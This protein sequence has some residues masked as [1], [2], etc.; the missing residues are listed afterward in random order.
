MK[1]SASA[2]AP[3]E[4][5]AKLRTQVRRVQH[6]RWSSSYRSNVASAVRRF[7]AC[8]DCLGLVTFPPHG[9][10]GDALTAW[11]HAGINGSVPS[12][13]RPKKLSSVRTDMRFLKAHCVDSGIPFLADPSDARHVKQYLDGASA[14]DAGEVKRP[15]PITLRHIGRDIRRILNLQQPWDRQVYV[16][17]LLSHDIM[18]RAS[19]ACGTALLRRHLTFTDDDFVCVK[20][21]KRKNNRHGG[22]A[23]VYGAPSPV[24]HVNTPVLLKRYL[25]DTGIYNHPDCPIFAKLDKRGKVIIPYKVL[26]YSAW[27]KIFMKITKKAGI[28]GA[29]PHALRAGGFTDAVGIDGDVDPFVVASIG[30]WAPYGAWPRY[31]RPEGK[32]VARVARMSYDRQLKGLQGRRDGDRHRGV[33]VSGLARPRRSP[34][35]S[36]R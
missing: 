4:R 29:T 15:T 18:L 28:E 35:S 3:S 2:Q 14:I 31:L 1:F 34:R 5:L 9:V 32:A 33:A 22:P 10:D 23:F 6:Q 7:R 21:V 13:P 25:K 19:D 16:H 11:L 12:Q 27:R 30:Q 20:L 8:C 26:S 17:L 36:R 24:A